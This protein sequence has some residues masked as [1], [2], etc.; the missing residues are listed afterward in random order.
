MENQL[1]KNIENKGET[2]ILKLYIRIGISQN[3]GY[4][5]AGPYSVEKYCDLCLA[6]MN[7]YIY[8]YM[9]QSIGTTM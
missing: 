5:F 4:L 2:A 1:E 3:L 9:W 6:P 8:I 7:V